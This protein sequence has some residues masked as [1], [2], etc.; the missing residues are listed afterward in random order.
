MKEF[1]LNTFD[2]SEIA[3]YLWDDVAEPI[4]VVQIAHGMGEHCGRYDAFAKYLNANGYMVIAEDHR[5]HG[6]TS[7]YD[8]R[9]IVEGD[10]YNDTVSDMIALT[11][12]AEK[13]Y[14]LPVVLLGHSYGSFLSQ[15]YIERNG[16]NIAGVILSGSAYMNTGA[17]AFGRIVASLQQAILGGKK[18]ANLI[19]KLSFGAYDK[20]FK[21]ENQPFAWLTRDVEAVHKYL[22]DEFCGGAF[23]MSIGFQKSFFYGLKTV[24]TE[25]ALESIPKTLPILVSSGSEDPVGGNGKLVTKLY[26]CYKAHGISDLTIKLYPEARHEILNEINKDEVYADFLAFIQRVTAK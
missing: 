2:N 17:V 9:G 5:G 7:G 16:E 8:N 20:Q 24:Y 11:N 3:C 26:D 14:K 22:A 10:S 13:K 18:P 1:S 23:T 12:Y 15:A 19:A 21:S 4:A 6:K 25:E